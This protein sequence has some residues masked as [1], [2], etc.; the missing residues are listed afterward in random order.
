MTFEGASRVLLPSDSPEGE[1]ECEQGEGG[2]ASAQDRPPGASGSW[3]SWAWVRSSLQLR[4]SAG[5]C[6]QPEKSD[7]HSLFVP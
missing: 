3:L 5:L 7:D 2:Q 6:M 1:S 4:S